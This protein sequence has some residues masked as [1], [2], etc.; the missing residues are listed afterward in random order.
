LIR[1]WHC[2]QEEWQSAR[3]AYKV[4]DQLTD[5]LALVS[6][7]LPE[8]CEALMRGARFLFPFGLRELY[9]RC[10]AFGPAR[11]LAWLKKNQ[12]HAFDQ[13]GALKVDLGLART[14]VSEIEVPN[15][16]AIPV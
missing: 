13:I 11:A 10:T 4:R 6:G 14:G 15:M 2:P 8:W 3:L 9:L 16:F 1:Q 5:P 7:A 12:P